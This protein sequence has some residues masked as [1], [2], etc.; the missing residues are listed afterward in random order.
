MYFT[1]RATGLHCMYSVL[2]DFWAA[3]EMKPQQLQLPSARSSSNPGRRP[4]YPL[5]FDFSDQIRP[6]SHHRTYRQVMKVSITRFYLK[7][8]LSDRH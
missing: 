4:F 3:G 1:N 2:I 8:L 6:N 5:Q 7:L